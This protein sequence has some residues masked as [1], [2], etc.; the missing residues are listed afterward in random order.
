VILE[1]N[2]PVPAPQEAFPSILILHAD[3]ASGTDPAAEDTYK[4]LAV[5]I[6]LPE[7]PPAPTAISYAQ[8]PSYSSSHTVSRSPVQN[9]AV[10]PAKMPDIMIPNAGAVKLQTPKFPTLFPIN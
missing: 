6:P 3:Q 8:K 4:F 2:V 9:Y 7:I 5:S 10:T 1:G